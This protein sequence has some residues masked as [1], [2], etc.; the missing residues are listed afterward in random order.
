MMPHVCLARQRRSRHLQEMLQESLHTEVRQCGTEEYRGELS[1]ADQLLIELCR[2]TI[3]QL[4]L[5]HQLCP[6]VS[7]PMNSCQLRIAMEYQ[8]PSPV[9]ASYPSRVSVK[10]VTFPVC[11]VVDTLEILSGTDRPV[12]RT[13]RDAQLLLN[14]VQQ[15]EGVVR[16]T[17]HLIDKGKNRNM[18]HDTD[19][20]QL[21]GLC[22][23]AL[24]SR[25]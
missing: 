8:P 18:A 25:R 21:A 22:L 9:Q 12:D 16:V 4:D 10:V 14:V 19:L 3:Q 6:Y 2:R 5:I 1:L 11:T 7:S 17:V 23:Y 20:E 15:L 24:G 13:G